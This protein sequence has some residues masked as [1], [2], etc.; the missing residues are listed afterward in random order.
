MQFN[1][2][3]ILAATVAQFIVGA[4]W[5]TFLFGK[6]WGKIHGFDKLPK[7]V[8]DEMMSQMG[9]IYGAQFVVTLLTSIVFSIFITMLPGDWNPYGMAFF[10]W[11][12]FTVPAIASAAFFGGTESKWLVTKIA[13]QA[14]GALAS[15]LAAAAVLS[16]MI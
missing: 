3:A 4:V 16:A 7:K 9:P 8:Q 6:L 15:L 14:F 2:P 12:G 1:I 5:Y 10:F 11:L 13:I